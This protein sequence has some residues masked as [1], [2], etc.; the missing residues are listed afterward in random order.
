[1]ETPRPYFIIRD[2]EIQGIDLVLEDMA[3]DAL[4]GA[5]VVHVPGTQSL[6]RKGSLFRQEVENTL[7]QPGL[8]VIALVDLPNLNVGFEIG[9]SLGKGF[10][11]AL[12]AASGD[13]PKWLQQTP[14]R[15][16]LCEPATSREDFQKIVS[17]PRWHDD[18]P[19]A[20]EAGSE[21]VVCCPAQGQGSVL[22]RRVKKVL[23]DAVRFLELEGWHAPE[24]HDQLAGTA[25][26]VWI[27]G[28]HVKEGERDGAENAGFALCAGY[29]RAHGLDVHVFRHAKA[30][31]AADVEA[32][33]KVFADL[34][35]LETKL[36]ALPPLGQAAGDARDPRGT[37]RRYLR[38]QHRDL[39]AFLPQA[40]DQM[41]DAIYVELEV[42]WE[43]RAAQPRTQSPKERAR[44]KQYTL[45]ELLELPPDD[46]QSQAERTA[47]G[48]WAILGDPGAGKTTIARHLAYEL[49]GGARRRCAAPRAHLAHAPL[50]REE[51]SVCVDR[52]RRAQCARR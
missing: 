46:V 22:R 8:R 21:L 50:A 23:G 40:K 16:T 18:V 1:M 36:L 44:A 25:R 35:E 17:D 26:L 30:R 20:P 14:L 9:Y 15:A 19:D 47:T 38:T 11:V 37:Y 43:E 41:L 28:E 6:P 48:R 3:D 13:V 49:G 29:A 12:A 2:F 4:E 39:M 42:R 27:I 51:T 7:S 32:Q 33:E 52:G 31:R 45:R 5:S 10:P 24:L 34:A